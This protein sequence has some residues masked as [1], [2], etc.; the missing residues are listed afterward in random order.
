M[1]EVLEVSLRVPKGSHILFVIFLTAWLVAAGAPLVH[2]D[3]PPRHE[4]DKPSVTILPQAGERPISLET[5]KLDK[6]GEG[7]GRR[8]DEI[9]QR[10]SRREAMRW[11][12]DEVALGITWL[13]L[14]TCNGLLL[15]VLAG[16]RLFTHWVRA[17]L[18]NVRSG[19]DVAGVSGISVR[20]FSRPVSFL[21]WIYGIYA[22]FSPLYGHFE[23][24]DGSNPFHEAMKKLTEAGGLLA[25]AWL[26][27]LLF[28]LGDQVF[29]GDVRPGAVR[30]KPF[31]HTAV[32]PS[33]CWSYSSWRESF[34]RCWRPCPSFT[35]RSSTC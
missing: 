30:P 10:A 17:V 31:G 13:K 27:Y 32:A 2:G 8:I 25:L 33:G 18:R 12:D 22:A 34:F 28:H 35:C 21:I 29:A 6:V 1:E 7:I 11:L 26:G 19:W 15:V 9:G 20:P 5:E 24:T 4:N 3:D 16:E 14:I 23:R